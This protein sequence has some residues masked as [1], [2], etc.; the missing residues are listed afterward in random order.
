MRDG[1]IAYEKRTYD[2]TGCLLEIGAL[3]AK[4]V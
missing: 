4:P 2:F 1:Q 3:K